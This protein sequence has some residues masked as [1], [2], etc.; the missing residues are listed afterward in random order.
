M[1]GSTHE[2]TYNTLKYAS[3]AKEIRTNLRQNVMKSNIPKEFY[4]KTDNE[5][6]ED[7][8]RLKRTTTAP[9]AKLLIQLPKAKSDL[10]TLA[11]SL[12]R[13]PKPLVL[14]ALSRPAK[15]IIESFTIRLAPVLDSF[16]RTCT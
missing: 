16:I 11:P 9:L 15:S 8:D 14:P 2:D 12:Y 6:K 7:I 3:R 4:V 13:N 5:L 10:F 1:S